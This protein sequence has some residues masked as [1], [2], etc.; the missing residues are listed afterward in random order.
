MEL[1]GPGLDGLAVFVEAVAFVVQTGAVRIPAAEI[2]GP[3]GEVEIAFRDLHGDIDGIGRPALHHITA[4]QQLVPCVP[5]HVGDLAPAGQGPDERFAQAMPLLRP[6]DTGDLHPVKGPEHVDLHGAGMAVLAGDGDGGAAQGAGDAQVAVAVQPGDVAVGAGGVLLVVDAP[7]GV[8]H[9]GLEGLDGAGH[10][11]CLA[12]WEGVRGPAAHVTGGLHLEIERQRAVFIGIGL[13]GAA[14]AGLPLDLYLQ[15][16]GRQGGEIVVRRIEVVGIQ[17]HR[18]L[19]HSGGAQARVALAPVAHGVIDLRDLLVLT[20]VLH[21]PHTDRRRLLG[22]GVRFAHVRILGPDGHRGARQRVEDLLVGRGA[23][24]FLHLIDTGLE[25]LLLVE[26]GGPLIVQHDGSDLDV[27][28][29]HVLRDIALVPVGGEDVVVLQAQILVLPRLVPLLGGVVP[30]VHVDHF[31]RPVVLVGHRGR[32]RQAVVAVA[33]GVGIV[34]V[35]G[36]HVGVG[37]V[38]DHIPALGVVQGLARQVVVVPDVVGTG[39]HADIIAVGVHLPP[40]VV[41]V[42]DLVVAPV[43]GHAG[44]AVAQLDIGVVSG[45]DA[46]SQELQ[47]RELVLLVGAARAHPVVEGDAAEQDGA[48]GLGRGQLLAEE[49]AAPV[50]VRH[51]LLH[52]Q[53]DAVHLA[54]PVALPVRALLLDLLRH[55]QQGQ[56]AL[57]GVLPCAVADLDQRIVGAVDAVFVDVLTG[58]GIHPVHLVGKVLHGGAHGLVGLDVELDPADVRPVGDPVIVP[59]VLGPRLLVHTDLLVGV[60]LHGRGV[61]Y[62]A[63]GRV[64]QGIAVGVQRRG[65]VPH[66]GILQE[67]A[68]GIHAGHVVVGVVTGVVE[69]QHDGPAVGVVRVVKDE[70]EVV[71]RLAGGGADVVLVVGPELRALLA[72][73][74]IRRQLHGVGRVGLGR[75]WID[76]Q[77]V[78]GA[79]LAVAAEEAVVIQALGKGAA[80]GLHRRLLLAAVVQQHQGAGAVVIHDLDAAVPDQILAEGLHAQVHAAWGAGELAEVVVIVIG[81]PVLPDGH[82][83]HVVEAAEGA[84][85]DLHVGGVHRDGHEGVPGRLVGGQ[86][87]LIIEVQHLHA[88][89]L[90]GL[91]LLVLVDPVAVHVLHRLAG[92]LGRLGDVDHVEDVG[93]VVRLEQAIVDVHHAAL[94]L[95]AVPVLLAVQLHHLDGGV[96]GVGGAAVAHKGAAVGHEAAVAAHPD[97]GALDGLGHPGLLILAAHADDAVHQ[98]EGAVH[99]VAD[100]ALVDH[101]VHH[102][103]LGL[104]QGGLG[105]VLGLAVGSGLVLPVRGTGAAAGVVGRVGLHLALFHRLLAAGT[106]VVLALGGGVQHGVALLGVQVLAVAVHHGLAAAVGAVVVFAAAAPVVK[107]VHVGLLLQQVRIGCRGYADARGVLR[108]VDA[109]FHRIADDGAQL[110][111]GEVALELVLLAPGLEGAAVD[112]QVAVVHMEHVPGGVGRD[113]IAVGVHHVAGELDSALALAVGALFPP[114]RGVDDGQRGALG[115]LEGHAVVVLLVGRLVWIVVSAVGVVP[116]VQGVAVQVQHLVPGDDHG[117]PDGVLVVAAVDVA[118]QHNVIERRVGGHQRLTDTALVVVRQGPAVHML[119]EILAVLRLDLRFLDLLAL[120]DLGVLGQV[121]QRLVGVDDPL[122]LLVVEVDGQVGVVA[123]LVRL[124]GAVGLRC[125]GF[126]LLRRLGLRGKCRGDQVG[127]QHGD[128]HQRHQQHTQ[129][130]FQVFHVVLLCMA[131]GLMERGTVEC[132]GHMHCIL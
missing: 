15:L 98:V 31:R 34:G 21:A 42:E 108:H 105:V 70:V 77:V 53:L 10:A 116:D 62:R 76:R 92:V 130:A 56:L 30:G 66:L 89:G 109:Q 90:A 24:Q 95:T 40:L 35:H 50:A 74:V 78:L 4:V 81:I 87:I 84:A 111:P 64:R 85:A 58:Q 16:F 38:V 14:V 124:A 115:D 13:A 45:S 60:A 3:V 106:G 43:V 63:V 120:K 118:V 82:I 83:H 113:V 86:L 27:V 104:G 26:G 29:Q 128:D 102:V 59:V 100:G 97:H 107:G 129:C 132:T 9:V 103:L 94:G 19:G 11:L 131:R 69:V 36:V 71:L 112:D 61:I 39:Q 79:Q 22:G 55:L 65:I 32:A 99:H 1:V 122:A 7:G 73:A 8:G 52:L 41:H 2:V 68:V 49:A 28:P 25:G 126:A 6:F 91:E 67:L 119:P 12:G 47:R 75:V 17:R 72:R 117:L 80:R 93:A 20:Q 48:L 114:G 54:G 88:T 44:P 18:Q 33:G 123:L 57:Q 127:G 125:A 121:E 37:R 110:L 46:R 96:A 23:G 5:L 101:L 51:V